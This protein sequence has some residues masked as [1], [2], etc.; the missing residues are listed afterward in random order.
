MR[1]S[2]QKMAVFP[3]KIAGNDSQ[4]HICLPTAYTFTIFSDSETAN[5]VQYK[6]LKCGKD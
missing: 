4:K 3:A 6:I 1:I 5:F 2:F